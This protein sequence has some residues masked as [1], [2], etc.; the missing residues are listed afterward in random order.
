MKIY[1][2]TQESE[3]DGWTGTM[4]FASREAAAAHLNENI[5][6]FN[7]EEGTTMNKV[8]WPERQHSMRI[9]VGPYTYHCEE[10]TLNK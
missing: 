1:V 4:V 6:E 9:T 3:Y 8:I 2:V 7:D 5:T 10:D